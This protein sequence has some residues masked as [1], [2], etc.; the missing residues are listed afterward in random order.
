MIWSVVQSVIFRIRVTSKE[1]MMEDIKLTPF[2]KEHFE[3][4]FQWLQDKKLRLAIDSIGAPTVEINKQYWERALAE[5]SKVS[6]AV[7]HQSVH[8]GNAGLVSIDMV[9]E[10]A[11]LW[12]YL[13][14]RR[15]QSLGR[16]VALAILSL[17]FQKLQLNRV[18]VRVLSSNP[19]GC[20]FFESLGFIKE[21]RLRE[22]TVSDDVRTDA[23]LYG[24]LRMEYERLS[25]LFG[26]SQ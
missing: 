15:N 10:K 19:V 3:Q 16:R 24:I 20:R 5:P 14:E 26:D 25:Q 22:D 9:R 4:T 7:L 17:A 2:S 13:A 11:E 12:I 23:I 1:I 18:Y 8:I 6:F 21:G